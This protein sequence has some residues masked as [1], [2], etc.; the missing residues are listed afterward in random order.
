MSRQKGD[1]IINGKV[2]HAVDTPEPESPESSGMA[3]SDSLKSETALYENEHSIVLM[4]RNH[5]APEVTM[6]GYWDGNLL[7]AAMHAI[8]KKYGEVRKHATV[9][10]MRKSQEASQLVISK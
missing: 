10:A 7:R 8:E 5:Q 9:Y 2:V 6:T 1:R 4:I 3:L